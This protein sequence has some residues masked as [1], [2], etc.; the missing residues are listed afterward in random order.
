[1][2]YT[3]TPPLCLH[4]MLWGRPFNAVLTF[5]SLFGVINVFGL[6]S[7][8]ICLPSTHKIVTYAQCSLVPAIIHVPLLSQMN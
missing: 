7:I 4:G 6:H 1:M 3:P 8:C 2:S 5:L